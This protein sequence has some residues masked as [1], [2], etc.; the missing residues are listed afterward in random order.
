M[1]SCIFFAARI[2]FRLLC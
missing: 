1:P 2:S